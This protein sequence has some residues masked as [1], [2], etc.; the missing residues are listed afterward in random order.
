MLLAVVAARVTETNLRLAAVRIPGVRVELLSPAEALEVVQHGDTVVGRLDVLPT[1]DGVD[2]GMWA[3]SELEA[4]GA[5]VLNGPS[6]LLA[7]HD[8][9]LT[10]R[11]LCAARL[12]HP[13]TQLVRGRRPRTL[14]EPPVVVKPRHGSWG[15]DV[16]RCDD[17]AQL[18]AVLKRLPKHPWYRVHGALVQELVPPL[19]HDLR[20]VVAGDEAIGAVSRVAAR[21]EWRTNVALGATRRPVEPPAEAVEIARAAARAVGASLVGV[22]LLP[23]DDGRWVVL[24]LNGA[25]EF[26]EVY[27]PSRDVFADATRA[28]VRTSAE[29]AAPEGLSAALTA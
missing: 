20:V 28:L 5:T 24:E 4:R 27:A 15:R 19:G 17:R 12:R 2:H 8:K 18:R 9:L 25:V 7:A 29:V 16:V 23:R 10:A 21:G 3:L 6:A 26:N 1:L 14:L 22:D 11:V 13:R